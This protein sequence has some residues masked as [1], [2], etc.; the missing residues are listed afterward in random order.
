MTDSQEIITSIWDKVEKMEA[1]PS[2]QRKAVPLTNK[3]FAA[4]LCGLIFL[5]INIFILG[6]KAYWLTMCCVPVAYLI[7]RYSWIEE[8]R[9][10]EAEMLSS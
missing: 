2:N 9:N 6:E 5:A 3:V 1:L 8:V 7:D 4:G 10:K